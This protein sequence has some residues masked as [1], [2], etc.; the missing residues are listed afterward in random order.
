MTLTFECDL[1]S[2]RKEKETQTSLYTSVICVENTALLGRRCALS[3]RDE[4][5][6]RMNLFRVRVSRATVSTHPQRTQNK[7]IKYE[8]VIQKAD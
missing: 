8:K 2:V 4:F 6:H 1:Y 5:C 7:H 3:N